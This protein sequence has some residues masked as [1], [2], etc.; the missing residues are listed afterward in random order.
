MISTILYFICD[1]RK[2]HIEE[3]LRMAAQANRELNSYLALS[4]KIAEDRERKRIAR[5]IMIR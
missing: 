5:E 3:E 1:D 2:H 4:E